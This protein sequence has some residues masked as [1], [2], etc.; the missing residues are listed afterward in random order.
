MPQ[1]CVCLGR[2][3]GAPVG[4]GLVGKVVWKGMH[5]CYQRNPDQREH[6]ALHPRQAH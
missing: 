1:L 4:A 5:D 2:G 3:E 6:L